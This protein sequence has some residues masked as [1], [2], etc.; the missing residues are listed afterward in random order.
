MFVAVNSDATPNRIT[1]IPSPSFPA[2][3]GGN[4]YH[5][6]GRAQAAPYRS[7]P[8]FFK[9][10][11]FGDEMLD[12]LKG[13]N[14]ALHDS[15]L[16][17]QSKTQYPPGYEAQSIES[18]AKFRRIGADGKFRS[19]DDLRLLPESLARYA[20]IELPAELQEMDG[21]V[22]GPPAIGCYRRDSGPLRVGVD[23][24]RAYPAP[25]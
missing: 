8:Y 19:D 1:F 18:D 5:R 21:A 4:N 6:I 7:L 15:E 16:F 23:E 24:G 12:C 13:C 20:G 17:K 11:K 10:K 3:T 9:N 14:D 22:K 25:P 2:R